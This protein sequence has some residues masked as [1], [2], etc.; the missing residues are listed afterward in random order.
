MTVDESGVPESRQWLTV[1]YEDGRAIVTAHATRRFGEREAAVHVEV[2]GSDDLD[3]VL[4]AIHAASQDD[5]EERGFDAASEHRTLARNRGE[6]HRAPLEAVGYEE[7]TAEAG[8]YSDPRLMAMDTPR[9]RARAIQR[10]VTAAAG[11]EANDE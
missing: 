11:P 3:G 6:D 9:A 5:L 2:E 7:I 1:H 10:T 8:V 4:A